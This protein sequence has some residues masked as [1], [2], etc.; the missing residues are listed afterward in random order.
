L[1]KTPPLS[2]AWSIDCPVIALALPCTPLWLITWPPP[3]EAAL[4]PVPSEEEDWVG[5]VDCAPSPSEEADVSPAAALPP[6]PTTPLL[7]L[8]D[9]EPAPVPMVDADAPPALPAPAAPPGAATPL[10]DKP[11]T[12]IA[13]AAAAAN[14]LTVILML[15]L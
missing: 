12:N 4:P 6:V 5:V 7:P 14:P 8:G 11:A 10:A 1:L 2:W 3:A 15:H 9:V 13:A